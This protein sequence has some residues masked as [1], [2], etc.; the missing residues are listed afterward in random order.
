MPSAAVK[1]GQRPPGVQ[2]HSDAIGSISLQSRLG[3]IPKRGD[4]V[5][6]VG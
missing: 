6:M 2:A 1:I 3:L 4:G 5:C